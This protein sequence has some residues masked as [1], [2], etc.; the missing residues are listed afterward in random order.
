MS[1]INTLLLAA[2]KSSRIASISKRFPKQ[3][4]KKRILSLNIDDIYAYNNPLL[5]N[6]LEKKMEKVMPPSIH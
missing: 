6:L 1:A 2:G 3:Y 4:M 5:I